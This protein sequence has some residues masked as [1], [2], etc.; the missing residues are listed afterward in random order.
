VH[1]HLAS[2]GVVHAYWDERESFHAGAFVAGDGVWGVLGEREAGKS[3]LLASLALRGTPVFCDDLLVIDGNTALAGPRS[4]DLRSGAASR[5]GCGEP[6]GV[7]GNRERFRLRL[8]PV[9]A[10]LPLKGWVELGWG[11]T[12]VVSPKRGAERLRALAPHRGLRL[13]PP[14]PESL[15]ALASL[16][17][18]ELR[19]RAEWSSHERSIDTLL[20]V[21]GAAGQPGGLRERE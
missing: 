5:L 6:L 9:P 8:H 20:E 19:R 17:M 15:L 21:V 11:E 16:P 4:I 12:D 2:V 1:P 7:V 18:Y 3:S 13:P 14:R 10:E